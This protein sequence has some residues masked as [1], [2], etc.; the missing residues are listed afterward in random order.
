VA[1]ILNPVVSNNDVH[2]SNNVVISDVE[3]G[4][5][6]YGERKMGEV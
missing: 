2:Q 5:K 4:N 1:Q 6:L 3:N